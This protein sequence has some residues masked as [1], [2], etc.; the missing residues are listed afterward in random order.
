VCTDGF[1][2]GDIDVVDGELVSV[3]KQALCNPASHVT[4]ANEA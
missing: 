2:L 4:Q 3:I 1:G